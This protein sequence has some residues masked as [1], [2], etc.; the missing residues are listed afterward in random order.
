M[1]S[2]GKNDCK[3]NT[4]SRAINLE[5]LYQLVCQIR[6]YMELCPFEANRPSVKKSAFFTESEDSL[7]CSQQSA[8]GRILHHLNPVW[9][10]TVFLRG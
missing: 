6:I 3:G 1:Q 7:L 8:T 5:Y 9:V 10:L 4:V 2:S